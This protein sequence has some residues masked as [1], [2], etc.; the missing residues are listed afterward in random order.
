MKKLFSLVVILVG[1]LAY[2][3]AA[4]AGP[5]AANGYTTSDAMFAGWADS[6]IDYSGYNANILGE[7][8]KTL[9]VGASQGGYITLGFDTAI[10]NGSGADFVVWENGFEVSGS[11]GLVYAELGYVSVSTNGTDWVIFPSVYNDVASGNPNIDPTNVYNLAGNYVAYYTD[12]ENYEGT[13]FD[14]D[15]LANTAEV[16]SGLVDLSNINFMRIDDIIGAGEGGTNYDEATYFGY[17]SDSLIYDGVSY[18][19]GADWNAVGVINAVPVPAAVW[20]LG[21]GLMGL[22]CVR[23]KSVN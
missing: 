8:D 19:G 9:A 10:T 15:D 5:Y 6:V 21:S 11:G 18:G 3:T 14:L 1:M 17:A 2:A 22:I 13:P 12:V 23:R 16:L 20:L 7:L 4:S